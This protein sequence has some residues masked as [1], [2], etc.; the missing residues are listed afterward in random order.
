M[1]TGGTEAPIHTWHLQD[2]VLVV[3]YLQMMIKETTCR[4][5]QEGR[6]DG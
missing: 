6:D 5:F 4:P 2:S 3:P 1:I